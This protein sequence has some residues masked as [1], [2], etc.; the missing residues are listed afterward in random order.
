MYV[1]I[2]IKNNKHLAMRLLITGISISLPLGS[3]KQGKNILEF[4][5][6][7]C[8]CEY[9]FTSNTIYLYSNHCKIEFIHS[10]FLV[11]YCVLKW[12]VSLRFVWA[13][14][15]YC[16]VMYVWDSIEIGVLRFAVFKFISAA[17]LREIHLKVCIFWKVKNNF[18]LLNVQQHFI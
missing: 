6:S 3:V 8:L 11:D 7:R 2:Y 14:Y 13:A 5:M 1:Y 17:C 12:R 16:C 10:S 18:L 4:W 9:L 15:H